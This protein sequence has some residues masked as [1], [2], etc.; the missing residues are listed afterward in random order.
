MRIIGHRIL[1][2][3]R[4]L[5]L[6]A[7]QYIDRL[8]NERT[9]EVVSRKSPPLVVSMDYKRPDA[10]VIV[11]YHVPSAS[12]VVIR[13]FRIPLGCYQVGFPAGLVDHGE[14]VEQAARRELLEETG[15]ELIGIRRVSPPVYSSSGMTDESVVMVYADCQGNPSSDFNESSERI[16]AIMLSR[17]EASMLMDDPALKF[18][19][20]TWL[21]L[22][23]FVQTG[24]I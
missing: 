18:D 8:G 3:G 17:H 13:E 15:L 6:Y 4:R 7:V 23:S 21:V 24:Q 10:V 2:K 9:W 20:K 11:P 5:F 16:E 22:R 19:V 1:H 14:A 12:L